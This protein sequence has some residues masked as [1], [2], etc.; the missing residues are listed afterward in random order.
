MRSSNMRKEER[1]RNKMTKNKTADSIAKHQASY[2]YHLLLFIIF[3]L[4]II[5]TF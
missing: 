1:Y 2:I 5:F 4:E 3:G